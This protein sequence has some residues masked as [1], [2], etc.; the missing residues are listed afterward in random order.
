MVPVI[1]FLGTLTGAEAFGEWGE[2]GS[3][4][5]SPRR[6]CACGTRLNPGVDGDLPALEWI[7]RLCIQLLEVAHVPGNDGQPVHDGQPSAATV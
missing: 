5:Y 6:A 2:G 1:F 3:N 4:S 7:Q